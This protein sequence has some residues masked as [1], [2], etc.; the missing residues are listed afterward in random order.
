LNA[1]PGEHVVSLSENMTETEIQELVSRQFRGHPEPYGG[2]YDEIVP[3]LTSR[4]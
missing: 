4:P 1:N 2:A 3:Y